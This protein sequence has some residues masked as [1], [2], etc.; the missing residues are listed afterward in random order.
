[1]A[2]SFAVTSARGVS[3]APDA[4]VSRGEGSGVLRS[5][6]VAGRPIGAVA[7]FARSRRGSRIALLA[8]LV[9]LPLLGGAWLWLRQSPLVSVEHVQIS[10]VHGRDARAIDA[11]LTTAARRMSTL[12]VHTGALVAA[13]AQFRVVA[14]L[15][16]SAS[17]PHGLRIEVIEQPPVA[18]LAVSGARTAV[19]ADGVVLGPALLSGS[20]PTVAAAVVPGTGGRVRGYNL[21]AVLTVLGAAPASLARLVQRAY[22]GPRG[23]TVVMRSGLVAY[24]GDATRPHAKWLSLARVLADPSSAGASYVDVRLPARPAAGFPEGVSPPGAGESAAAVSSGEQTSGSGSPVASLA[25]GLSAGS[26]PSTPSEPGDESSTE[27]APSSA[28]AAPATPAGAQPESEAAG[29]SASAPGE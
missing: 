5:L 19:A 27:S 9:A 11:A 26:E 6:R 21:R 24:L 4:R 20:L 15:R 22:T 13:V 14:G 1:M 28:Q 2:R 12:D 8:T 10:G 25:A 29:A 18:A 7:S 17:P 23:L 16:A 3:H